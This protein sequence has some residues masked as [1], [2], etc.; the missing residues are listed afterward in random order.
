[1]FGKRNVKNLSKHSNILIL[2][3]L[4]K[5]SVNFKTPKKIKS[6]KIFFFFNFEYL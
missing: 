4:V 2:A 1:M 3:K 5:L 6:Y